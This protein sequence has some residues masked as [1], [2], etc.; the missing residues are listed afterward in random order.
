MSSYNRRQQ[1]TKVT[2]SD[3]SEAPRAIPGTPLQQ[4][5]TVLNMH[6]QRLSKITNYLGEVEKN[7]SLREKKYNDLLEKFSELSKKLTTLETKKE[8]VETTAKNSVTLSIEE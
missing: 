2:F 3:S 7:A 6:E 1:N 5:W 8:I 4:M